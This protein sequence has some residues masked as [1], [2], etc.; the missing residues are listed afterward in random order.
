MENE[1]L[2]DFCTSKTCEE[3]RKGRLGVLLS[4]AFWYATEKVKSR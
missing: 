4:V 3:D 2:I 1:L